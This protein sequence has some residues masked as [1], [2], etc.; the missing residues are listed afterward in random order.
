[1]EMSRKWISDLVEPR[2]KGTLSQ[3]YDCVM[4]AAI[5]MGTLPLLFRKQPTL[6]WYLD[7]ISAALYLVDYVLRWM[8]CDLRSKR[9]KWQAFLIYPFTPIAIFDLLCILPTFNVVAP[10]Y[11]LTKTTR[12]FKIIRFTRIVK[13]VEPLDIF[14]A[15]IKNQRRQLL[16][17]FLLAFF[18]ILITAIIMFQSEEEIDPVT[19][20]FIFESFYDAFYWAAIT[21]TTVGYGDFYPVSDVGR[22]LS[23]IS[24]L[25][26]IA[27][28]ALPS[29]ILTAGYIQELNR[30]LED[31]DK[32]SSTTSPCLP[33]G[34]NSE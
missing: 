1:M 32:T 13:Y 21:L 14:L 31:K 18:D 10:S 20:K 33:S 30:R 2:A 4:L 16:A 24:S 7:I 17:V 5:A 22:T 11:K 25:I 26:G 8:T 29:S 34:I 6:F 27:I 23:I 28:I 15:V 19:G 12:L 9:P 3:L